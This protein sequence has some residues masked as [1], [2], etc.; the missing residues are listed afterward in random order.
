VR[1]SRRALAHN[2]MCRNVVRAARGATSI[3]AGL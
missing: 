2:S 1:T 3:R